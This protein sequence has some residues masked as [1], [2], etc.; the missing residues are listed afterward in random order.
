MAP[1]ATIEGLTHGYRGLHALD[2]VSISIN[3]GS[4]TGIIGPDGVGKSTLLG[5]LAGVVRI[6]VGRVTV[7]GG[8][9][10]D[11]RHRIRVCNDIAYMPQGLGQALYPSLTT[12]ENIVHIADL[13]G[14]TS[15]RTRTRIDEL[16]ELTDLTSVANRS[17][18]KLSGGMKQKLA[19][20]CVLVREPRLIVL[21]EPTT[22]VDPLSRRNLWAIVAAAREK[23]PDLSVVVATAY[24]EEAE[25]FDRVVMMSDARVLAEGTA[26][27]I[28]KRAGSPTLDDAYSALLSHGAQTTLSLGATS[29]DKEEERRD[30]PPVVIEG[31]HLTRKFG[32]F[33]AVDDVSFSIRKGEIFGFIGP[34][35]CGKTT[36][37]RMLTGL[38]VPTAGDALVLGQAVEAGSLSLRRKLGYMSQDFTLYD[39]L[40]VQRNLKLH[41]RLFDQGGGE[42]AARVGELAER[43]SLTQA[44]KRRASEIPLGMR[45]RLSLAVAVIHRPEIL[46]LDEPTSGVDPD[47]RNEFWMLLRE[48]ARNHGATV[49]VTTHYLTEA[50]RC[51]R[52]ALMHR[53]RLLATSTPRRLMA[54][55][56]APSLEAAF[57]AYITE[58][59]N[60]GTDRQARS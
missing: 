42:L 8:D 14:L 3:S 16:L 23:A 38:I 55:R 1:V 59:E 39:E 21:D 37:I 18:G 10:R 54:S 50:A 31:R 25:A 24:M 29:A 33:T 40:T 36:T 35:G 17:S 5:L 48:L 44:M 28:K 49:F 12:R 32:S 45:Q 2:D 57:V 52:I 41:G 30:T 4:I 15:A 20:C 11:R 9:M 56:Q 26:A 58:A 34:N 60:A 22:G 53:G 47:A 43:F 6:Q 13:F 46:I 7:L 19:L 27:E 51:D